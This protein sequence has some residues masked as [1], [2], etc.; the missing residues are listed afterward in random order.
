MHQI[1]NDLLQ[2]F[3]ETVTL[4]KQFW[5]MII[6]VLF[7]CFAVNV[8]IFGI[9]AVFGNLNILV[10]I[11]CYVVILVELQ[12][13]GV[14]LYSASN[15]NSL[16]KEVYNKLNGFYTRVDRLVLQTNCGN[17]S[18]IDRL[19]NGINM[20]GK[21]SNQPKM[22]RFHWPYPAVD[23]FFS[24]SRLKIQSMMTTFMQNKFGFTCSN[25]FIVNYWISFEVIGNR[26]HHILNIIYY[27]FIFYTG[28]IDYDIILFE[29]GSNVELI[30]FD[31]LS[32]HFNRLISYCPHFALFFTKF[33]FH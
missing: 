29:I 20:N 3:S 6:G 10:R 25:L 9:V 14:I 4:N 24:I 30:K 26:F 12:I 31:N 8:S 15:V 27:F 19:F 5:S 33:C 17:A 32:H 1:Y 2:I 13:F 7:L 18:N 16:S 28:C 22:T 23:Y 11:A 21:Q